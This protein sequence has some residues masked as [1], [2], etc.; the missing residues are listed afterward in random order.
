MSL[1]RRP[2]VAESPSRLLCYE[3]GK[4]DE[5]DATCTVEWVLP[6]V[7][8]KEQIQLMH[9]RLK[10]WCSTVDGTVGFL[11]GEAPELAAA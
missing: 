10:T 2:R 7:L 1:G 6:R 3:P 5:V 9:D 11:E 8:Q 4:I